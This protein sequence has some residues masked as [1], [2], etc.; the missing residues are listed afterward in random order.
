[1]IRVCQ[2][3]R[4]KNCCK[5]P[6][7]INSLFWPFLTFFRTSLLASHPALLFIRYL[8]NYFP[9]PDNSINK[10]EGK[11]I[12]SDSPNFNLFWHPEELSQSRFCVK[13]KIILFIFHFKGAMAKILILDDDISILKETAKWLSR[14]GHEIVY[15]ARADH[16]EKKSARLN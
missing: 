11:P 10:H 8:L 15:I 16:V 13:M 3:F 14:L 5:E 6:F 1:M 7:K 9:F 4:Y 2:A 12:L